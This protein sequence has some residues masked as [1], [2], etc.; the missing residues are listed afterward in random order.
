MIEIGMGSEIWEVGGQV[1]E[2]NLRSSGFLV[3]EENH[4]LP[5][6][7]GTDNRLL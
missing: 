5:F 4:W 3:L 1:E 2:Y 7:Q 6:I